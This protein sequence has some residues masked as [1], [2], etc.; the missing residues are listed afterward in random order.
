MT[1]VVD[2]YVNTDNYDTDYDFVGENMANGQTFTGAIGWLSS[3][4]VMLKRVG[5]PTG[6]LTAKIYAM[7]GTYGSTGKP[8]GTALATS[9]S[10]DVS[11]IPTDIT[12]VGFT[13]SG[14]NKIRLSK[15]TYYCLAI[16]A[17]NGW[18]TDRMKIGE[19]ASSP[20]HSGNAF[21]KPYGTWTQKATSDVIFWVY[22]DEVQGPVPTF[23]RTV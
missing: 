11:Q 10:W 12:L 2:L 22:A 21:Y 3:I 23:F 15:N 13:F 18:A 6:T 19:D 17:S 9:N 8:T 5:N 1:I 20:T 7:T 4:T 16:E 14:A